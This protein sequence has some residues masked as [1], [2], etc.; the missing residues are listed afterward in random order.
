M[1]ATGQSYSIQATVRTNIDLNSTFD[2]PFV[3]MNI[4]AMLIACYGLFENSR[5]GTE[6][7]ICLVQRRSTGGRRRLVLK[8]PAWRVDG[9]LGP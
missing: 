7:L 1:A 5:G 3:T 9:P 8:H 6:S 4:L 2:V